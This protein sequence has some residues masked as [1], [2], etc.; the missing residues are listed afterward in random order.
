MLAAGEAKKTAVVAPEDM[1]A[2]AESGGRSLGSLG[3][4]NVLK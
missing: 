3:H 1:V 4:T 2:R